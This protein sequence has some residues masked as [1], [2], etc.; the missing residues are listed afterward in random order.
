LQKAP[1]RSLFLGASLAGYRGEGEF[2][3][4]G[5]WAEIVKEAKWALKFDSIMQMTGFSMYDSPASWSMK[6]RQWFGSCARV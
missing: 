5:S 6:N 4:T 1:I 2:E 3:K